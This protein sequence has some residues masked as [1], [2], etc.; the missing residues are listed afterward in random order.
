[1]GKTERTWWEILAT[2]LIIAIIV[3]LFKTC[4]GKPCPAATIVEVFDSGKQHTVTQVEE[5]PPI[6]PR[7]II[8]TKT[9]TVWEDMQTTFYVHDTLR[10][11]VKVDSAKVVR[12]Y[13]TNR[14]YS[15]TNKVRFTIPNTKDTITGNVIVKSNVNR[16][17]LQSQR[18]FYDL[19]FPVLKSSVPMKTAFFLGVDVYGNQSNYVQMV[20][21][22]LSLLVKNTQYV[23]G[24]AGGK[25]LLIHVGLNKKL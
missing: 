10:M 22:N 15:D 9:D 17:R 2:L 23:I 14:N 16:N 8:V 13:Y 25:G 3:L 11:P 7:A 12:D 5:I 6:E 24:A 19:K 21:A 4:N 20:G 1:M 18:L